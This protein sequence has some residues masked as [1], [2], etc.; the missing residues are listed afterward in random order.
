MPAPRLK[1]GIVSAQ[2]SDL[3]GDKISFAT[4]T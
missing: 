3:I 4:A 1:D 2:T